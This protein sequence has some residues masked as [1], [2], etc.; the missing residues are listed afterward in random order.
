MTAYVTHNIT[1]IVSI[2]NKVVLPGRLLHTLLT[3][4]ILVRSDPVPY[5]ICLTS[6]TQMFEYSRMKRGFDLT[7]L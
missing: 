5:T 1:P 6:L 4:R 3:P 2:G 7:N